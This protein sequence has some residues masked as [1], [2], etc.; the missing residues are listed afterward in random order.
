MQE[1]ITKCT[2]FV[3]NLNLTLNQVSITIA[4]RSKT[5]DCGYSRIDAFGFESRR[6]HGFFCCS[7]LSVVF[8]Q[9]EVSA[10]N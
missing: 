3:F 4:E 8:C 10:T 7:F 6:G 5:L 9:V 1:S 2:L